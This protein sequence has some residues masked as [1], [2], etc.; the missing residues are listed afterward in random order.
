[1]RPSV[2]QIVAACAACSWAALWWLTDSRTDASSSRGPSVSRPA[3]QKNYVTPAQLVES[4]AVADRTVRAF[5]AVASDGTVFRWSGMSGKRPLVLVFIRR[6]CPCNVDFE[7]FFSRL[8]GRYRDVA[9]FAGVI[10][11]GADAAVSYATA[12]ETPYRVLADPD[13]AIINRF[14]AKNGGFVALLR[15]EGAIDTLWPGWSAEMMRE[16]GCRIAELGAVTERSIDV[17]GMPAAVSTGCPFEPRP[18]S[19]SAMCEP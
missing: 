16:L 3:T 7:P 1:M 2:P 8:A 12:N 14:E 6:D 17:A 13:R 18:A 11:A 10:D 4:G 9:E 19:L 5:S 15:P